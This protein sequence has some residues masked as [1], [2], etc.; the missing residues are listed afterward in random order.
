MF[1]FKNGPEIEMVLD[2]SEILGNILN[3]WENDCALVY[4]A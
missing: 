4:C 3:I 1:S 2:V